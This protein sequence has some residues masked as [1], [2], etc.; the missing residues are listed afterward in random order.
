MRPPRSTLAVLAAGAFAAWP[1]AAPSGAAELAPTYQSSSPDRGAMMDEAPEE[2][3]VTFSEPLDPSSVMNVVDECGNEIDS[4]PATVQLN[5]M[6]VGIGK[7]PSGTYEV[8]YRA[9][10]VGDVTGTTASSFEFMVHNGKPCGGGAQIDPCKEGHGAHGGHRDCDKKKNKKHDDHRRREHDDHE[11]DDHDDHVTGGPMHP[12]THGS[13]GG[14]HAGHGRRPMDGH[15]KHDEHGNADP[16]ADPQPG[17]FDNPP[18]ATG[19]GGSPIQAD[20]EAMLIGLGLALAVGV[21]GGWLLR[22]SGGVTA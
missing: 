4:G 15:G 3:R 2:V 20:P 1:L 11:D 12:D 5:E 9:V 13:T 10:G 21:L 6:T 17:D 18:F 8:V 7:T 22:V 14:N 19:P 16:P